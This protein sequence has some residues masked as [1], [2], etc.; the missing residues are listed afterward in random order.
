V[1][2]RPVRAHSYITGVPCTFGFEPSRR[3]EKKG[4]GP[5]AMQNGLRNSRIIRMV[6]ILHPNQVDV[7]PA[8]G[9][10]AV[11]SCEAVTKSVH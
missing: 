4:I 2:P 3:Q 6:Q 7:L 5:A 9:F 8:D 11:G 1:G 10:F